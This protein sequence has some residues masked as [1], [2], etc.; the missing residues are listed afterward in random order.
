MPAMWSDGSKQRMRRAALR[1]GMIRTEDSDALT[2]ILEPEAAVLHCLDNQAPPLLPGKCFVCP[3]IG[4]H[5][6]DLT[7]L[8]GVLDLVYCFSHGC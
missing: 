4:M 6:Q 5:Q 1:A 8:I 2:I 7:H 3:E